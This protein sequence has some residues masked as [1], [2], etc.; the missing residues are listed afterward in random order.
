MKNYIQLNEEDNV[1]VAISPLKKNDILQ[2]GKNR[3]T[4]L[5]DIPPGHKIAVRDI[6]KKSSV[7]KYG[8]SIGMALVNITVG[9]H[10]HIHNITSK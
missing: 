4:I 3:I 5:D 9:E 2:F 10:V 1:V 8:L 6:C 7:I